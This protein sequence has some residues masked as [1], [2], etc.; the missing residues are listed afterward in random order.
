MLAFYNFALEFLS[1][2]RRTNSLPITKGLK[3]LSLYTIHKMADR[4]SEAAALYGV[5]YKNLGA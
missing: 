2:V 1:K 4:L 5:A 3:I